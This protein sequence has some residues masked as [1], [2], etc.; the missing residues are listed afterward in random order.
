MAGSNPQHDAV[1]LYAVNCSG[2][3]RNVASISIRLQHRSTAVSH[4]QRTTKP[5]VQMQA[6]FYLPMQDEYI[7]RLWERSFLC[8]RYAPGTFR[9]AD[10]AALPPRLSSLRCLRQ[11]TQLGRPQQKNKHAAAGP[12]QHS[13]PDCIESEGCRAPSSHHPSGRPSIAP[14]AHTRQLCRLLSSGP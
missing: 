1:I 3:Q 4:N 5:Y 2:R 11:A 7:H 8:S 6:V 9:A 13:R 10:T 12:T 14:Q